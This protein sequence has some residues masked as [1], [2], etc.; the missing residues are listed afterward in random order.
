M[1]ATARAASENPYRV[2]IASLR[3]PASRRKM[4]ECLDQVACL[5]QGLDY[6]SDNSGIGASFPWEQLRYRHTAAI[7]AA[8]TA[9]RDAVTGRRW[10]AS[11]VN[12]CLVALRKVLEAAWDL[13]F[14]SSDAYQRARKVKSLKAHRLPAGRSIHGDEIIRMRDACL[15]EEG[16]RGI[17]RADPRPVDHWNPRGRG[18][19][20]ADRVL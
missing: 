15:A 7:L 3:S 14:I 17:R 16:P 9:H 8:L 1:P 5:V 20:G 4:A 11:Y 2:Y 13:E 12:C 18:R 10:S 6:G 19:L